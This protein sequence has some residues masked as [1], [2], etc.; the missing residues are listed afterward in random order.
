MK[1]KNKK[2]QKTKRRYVPRVR[3]E[4]IPKQQAL[5]QSLLNFLVQFCVY[6]KQ[7]HPLGVI[8]PADLESDAEAF[9]RKLNKAEEEVTPAEN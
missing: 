4:P 1:K 9:M 5:D 7:Q 6:L 2:K 8:R 3:R